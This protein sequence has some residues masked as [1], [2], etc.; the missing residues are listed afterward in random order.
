MGEKVFP[1]P[2]MWMGGNSKT[3][4]IG[5]NEQEQLGEV[6]YTGPTHQAILYFIHSNTY[7]FPSDGC[8]HR[9]GLVSSK[10]PQLLLELKRHQSL[11]PILGTSSSYWLLYWYPEHISTPQISSTG[12]CVKQR[13]Y[14]SGRTF[15]FCEFLIRDH[16]NF[17]RLKVSLLRLDQLRMP[18]NLVTSP[19]NSNLRS[20]AIIGLT[21]RTLNTISYLRGGVSAAMATS[22]T[23][24][25]TYLDYRGRAELLR[26]ILAQA[27]VNFEDNRI[28]PQDWAGAVPGTDI[29]L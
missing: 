13:A 7:W 28:K 14:S 27:S 20:W 5:M 1:P 18:T 24:K 25:L 6:F 22:S 19:G 4:G 2:Q 10:T 15:F 12:L 9:D 8:V 16:Q 11:S 29:I 26:F 21:K 3:T 23:I 17:E